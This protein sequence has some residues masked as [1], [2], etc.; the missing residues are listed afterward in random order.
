MPKGGRKARYL[1]FLILVSFSTLCL[2]AMITFL[3]PRVPDGFAWRRPLTG[4][5]FSLLCVLGMIAVFFPQHCARRS[6]K[7][8]PNSGRPDVSPQREHDL[9]KSSSIGGVMVTHGHHPACERYRQHEFLL[10][11]KTLCCACMGLFFGALISLA[12]ASYVFLLQRPF[13]LPDG[14]TFALGAV[15][16]TLGLAPYVFADAQGPV[17]RFSF[18]ALMIVGMLFALVGADSRAHSFALNAL[19]IGFFVLALFTRIL[20]SQDKHERICEACGLTCAA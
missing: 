4:S 3:S 20:L 10:G 2:L 16:V 17:R 13:D 5:I 6:H 14:L 11:K 18:N 8:Y 7:E 9:Q 12:G 15:G 1:L 19:L